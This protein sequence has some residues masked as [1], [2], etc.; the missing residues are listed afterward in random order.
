MSF[1]PRA[2]SSTDEQNAQNASKVEEDV[3]ELRREV[4][5]L[6][7]ERSVLLNQ[8]LA[9]DDD[10]ACLEA[11]L[12]DLQAKLFQKTEELS[13]TKT[14]YQKLTLQLEH[15]EKQRQDSASS[16]SAERFAYFIVV[17]FHIYIFYFMFYI[18]CYNLYVM[19][20]IILYFICYCL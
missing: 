20:Y 13:W 4:I 14:Q 3:A 17:Y 11:S 16:H 18:L 1:D 8:V 9:K 15:L 2:S 12:S 5:E 19:L 6:R 7:E 10:I